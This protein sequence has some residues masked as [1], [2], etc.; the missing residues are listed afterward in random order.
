MHRVE[1]KGP[2]DTKNNRNHPTVFLMHRVELKAGQTS[3][4]SRQAPE[5][6]S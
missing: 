2:R 1:L 6:G 4:L 5:R 3:Q